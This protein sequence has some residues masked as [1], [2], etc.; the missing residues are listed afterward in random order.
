MCLNLLKATC[1]DVFLCICICACS[2]PPSA[3]MYMCED[4]LF[5][6]KPIREVPLGNYIAPFKCPFPPHLYFILYLDLRF[7]ISLILE[8]CVSLEPC[9]FLRA[10]ALR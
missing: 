2:S 8:P 9:P 6:H 10:F 7:K 3:V 1:K 4:A 5:K